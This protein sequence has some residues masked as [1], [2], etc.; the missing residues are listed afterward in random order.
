MW[1]CAVD[2]SGPVHY[3][4]VGGGDHR[5][6]R[7]LYRGHPPADQERSPGPPLVCVHGLGGSALNWVAV[8]PTLAQ[9]HRVLA[10]DLAGFGRTP[11]A[12]R[13]AG[14]HANRR[15]LDRFLDEIVGGPAILV[16]NSMG[17]TIAMLQAAARPEQVVGLILVCPSV[18]TP[19]L[20]HPDREV[21]RAFAALTVPALGSLLLRQRCRRLGPEGLVSES[22]R[23]CC[24]DPDRVPRAALQALVDATRERA[25]MPW[26]NIAYLQAARS[27]VLLHTRERRRFF[28]RLQMIDVPTLLVQGAADR[29]APLAAAQQIARMRPD[30]TFALL[31]GVGHLPMLED[32]KQ[33]LSVINAWLARH[34][35]TAPGSGEVA[36]P[37]PKRPA[38]PA[39]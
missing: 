30:W 12:G 34:G 23:M 7:S 27:L 1:S 21:T 33:L 2:L 8:A 16:G 24:V 36:N 38:L 28:K 39:C 37:L 13:S 20:V 5:G 11:L 29:L 18:P 4:D 32:P 26:A 35:S 19:G 10:V 3:T 9:R 25:Q 14:I 15:L 22:L 6:R 17:G 31:D